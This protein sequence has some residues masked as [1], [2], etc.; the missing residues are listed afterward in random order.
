MREVK[1]LV[2]LIVINTREETVRLGCRNIRR[3]SPRDVHSLTSTKYSRRQN[4]HPPAL[5][6]VGRSRRVLVVTTMSVPGRGTSPDPR[7]GT[8]PGPGTPVVLR[9]RQGPSVAHP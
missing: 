4:G 8:T 9:R 1:H 2:H 7:H 6:S 5:A 3:K